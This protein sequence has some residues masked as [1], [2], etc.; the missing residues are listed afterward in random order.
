[1]KN[2]KF[3]SNDFDPRIAVV[4]MEQTKQKTGSLQS[5]FL[6]LFKICHKDSSG[7]QLFALEMGRV[8]GIQ[9]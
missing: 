2:T 9:L 7:M 5:S 6:I 3:S 1:M 4:F 8:P